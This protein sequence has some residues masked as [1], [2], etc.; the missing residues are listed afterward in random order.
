MRLGADRL[1][2]RAQVVGD[3]AEGRAH[4]LGPAG[5][6][7]A[8][9]Q[10]HEQ[11][12]VR[13]HDQRVGAVAA[14][15]D[16]AQLGHDGRAAR[17]GGVHVQP[18]ALASATSAIAGTGSMLVVEVVPDAWP[19]TAKGVKPAARSSATALRSAADVHAEARR[20]PGSCAAPPGRC[21]GR[22]PP[23][24]P[25]NGR[26]RTRTCAA[27]PVRPARGAATSSPGTASRA[28]ASAT[29]VDG[30]RG[31]LDDAEEA[32]G[33]A[34]SPGAASRGR[35]PRAR[36]PRAPVFH[37]MP[38]TLRAAVRSSPRIAGGVEELAK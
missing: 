32:G 37:N 8:Q 23:S 22:C 28:A 25:T 5:V 38:L 34:E 17:V 24:R 12:L 33:K 21:R 29:R 18:Q 16:V 2:G 30:G 36:W 4:D 15:E 27:A 26:A 11:P 35:R 20:P 6:E 10:G 3:E 13:V 7:H 9:V 19:S 1:L 14:V 31:V